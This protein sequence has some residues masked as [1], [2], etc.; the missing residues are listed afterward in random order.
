M[1]AIGAVNLTGDTIP[2]ILLHSLKG[3]IRLLHQSLISLEEIL[4][5]HKKRDCFQNYGYGLKSAEID[6]LSSTE[7]FFTAMGSENVFS[8]Q[9]VC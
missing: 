3:P 9:A 2:V 6:S 5:D 1:A 4:R 8:V 7:S